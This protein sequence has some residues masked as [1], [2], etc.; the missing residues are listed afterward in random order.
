MHNGLGE[1]Q[2]K[3][4][5]SALIMLGQNARKRTR[6]GNKNTPTKKVLIPNDWHDAWS[7]DKTE[8]RFALRRFRPRNNA[9]LPQYEA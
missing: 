7:D 2:A 1:D 4:N 6:N 5:K 8:E 3:S 9:D